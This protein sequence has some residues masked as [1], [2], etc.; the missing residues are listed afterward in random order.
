[1]NFIEI[2]DVVKRYSGHTALDGV[3]ISVPKG[4]IY[5]LLGPNGAGKTSLIRIINRITRQDSDEVLLDGRPIVDDDVA[6]I[7]YLPEDRKRDGIIA[8]LSVRENII[9]ADGTFSKDTDSPQTYHRDIHYLQVPL[10]AR[11]ALGKEHKGAMGYLILGPQVGWMLGDNAVHSESWTPLDRINGR[12]E[13]YD[14]AI[15]NR[16]DYG[17][18]GGLGCEL[19]P[20][21]GHF[22]VE[23][24]YYFG[25]ANIFGASKADAFSRSA[26]GAIVGKVTYLLPAI[27]KKKNAH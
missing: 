19:N 14:L 23:G 9:L 1:M 2:K 26:N 7:G 22:L 11:L 12:N 15:K 13:Q 21:A 5:G 17:I 27:K 6:R 3:T 20:S 25:L 8:D 10:L 4:C 18:T 16:F 24:R